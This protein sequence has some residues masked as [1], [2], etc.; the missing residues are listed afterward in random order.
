VYILYWTA[1]VGP[2]G[3][4]HFRDD[5]Y[6]RDHRLAAALAAERRA[7]APDLARE[8]GG[9]PPPREEGSG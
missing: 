9:C 4:V 7:G 2:D 3:L 8:I 1:F 6:E 5:V